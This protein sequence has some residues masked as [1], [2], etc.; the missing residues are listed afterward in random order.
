MKKTVYSAI[1]A[2][3][4][5][6]PL[7]G[8]ED[9]GEIVVTSTSKLPQKLSRTTAN[10][11]VITAE[12]IEERGYQSVTEVLSRISGL[13][14]ASNG[15]AGQTGSV[16]VRGLKGDNILILIDGIPLTDYTQPSSAA[17]L[18]HI[19]I[20]S[21]KQIE[22]IK[23]G[24]SGIWGASAA[25]GTINIVTKGGSKNYGSVK[26]KAGS[27]GTKGV[28][29]GISKVF[30][31]GSIYLGGN[32]LDTDGFS[33]I[34]PADAEADG[35]RNKDAHIKTSLNIDN[36]NKVSFFYHSYNGK[37]DFDSSSNA[38]D[39]L[40][41][42]DSDQQIL[43][44]EY[45]YSK[46]S[47][48]IN[49]KISKRDIKRHL[50]GTGS[51][52]SWVYDTEGSSTSYSIVANY[53]F[54]EN[55]SLTMAAEHTKNK[56][57]TDS[58]FGV[59]AES[60]KNSAIT[61][62]YSHTVNELLGAKTTFNAVLRYDKFDKFDDKATYRFG[63]KRECMEIDG[64]HASANIY[65]GYKAPSLFQFSNASGTL[66]PE[67]IQGYE[68]SI[69]YKKLLNITYFSNKIKDK[70]DSVYDPTTFTT[71]YFNNGDGV[72]VTGIELSGEYSFGES[73][74]ITGFNLTHMIDYQDENGKDLQ[75]IPQ[76]S[77]SAYLDYYFAEDSHI[78]IMANYVGK[79]RDIYYDPA[80]SA[81]T[82]VMLDSYTTVDITY[83]TKISDSLNLTISAKN[84]FDKQ[85]ETVKGY[86]TE[87]R[88][89]YATMEYRF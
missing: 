19:S 71:N 17:S 39:T 81:Q 9:I 21:I 77:I 85:Y 26:I 82:D 10:V 87:G 68:L 24:Q 32:I 67:S 79:R 31:A 84:I 89:I 49:A 23:G 14:F 60:F 3:L 43:G 29:F 75:R 47:L 4:I 70:I 54:S 28:G 22:V 80:T 15:G 53:N 73:G 63:I 35:Y 52:G 41:K 27:H 13:T 45:E 59:T 11:T 33:A 44:L 34:A 74:F 46:E 38:N 36:Y 6:S 66:K 64:L 8:A 56:A 18:E 69:G 88:S 12:D 78:G 58:G 72:K 16:F 25:A 5:I 37:F 50:E 1:T 20:E 86:S 61:A 55:Q 42:G 51:W 40:S 57:S 7:S 30:D 62:D 2:A 76:N 65:T 48:A 83:N